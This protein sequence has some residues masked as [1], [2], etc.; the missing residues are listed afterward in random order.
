MGEIISCKINYSRTF[1]TNEV[2]Q[3]GQEPDYQK[4]RFG[5]DKKECGN[6]WRR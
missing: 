4:N 1:G 2:D 3:N 5:D 6:S